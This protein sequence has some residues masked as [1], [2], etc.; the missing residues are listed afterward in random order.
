MKIIAD[1]RWEGAGLLYNSFRFAEFGGGAG[2]V[3]FAGLE[4]VR[5]LGQFGRLGRDYGT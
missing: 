3:R 2:E 5:E 1:R 4:E